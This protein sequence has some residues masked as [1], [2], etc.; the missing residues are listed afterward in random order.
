M[1]GLIRPELLVT[2]LRWREALIGLGVVALGLYGLLTTFGTLFY[3]SLL[4]IPAG[5]ALIW[6]GVRRARFPGG[7]Q[8]PGVVEIDER[9]ITYFGPGGGAAVSINALVRVEV[10]TRA[11][12]PVGSDHVWVFHST[13]AAPLVIP[14][15]AVGADGLFDALTALPGVD[16][17]QVTAAMAA[18]G[19]DRFVIWA[20]TNPDR[21][22][23]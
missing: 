17:S 3:L 13:E 18:T 8:G 2:I 14:G 4:A 15:D 10:V 5:I 16:Y 22:L 11:A 12:A 21:R 19:P 9:Q 1:K 23:S 20:G 6:E 7:G